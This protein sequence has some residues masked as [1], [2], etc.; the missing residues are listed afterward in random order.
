MPARSWFSPLRLLQ[1]GSIVA[2]AAIIGLWGAISWSLERERAAVHARNNVEL[3]REYALRV[4]ET[5][6][7]LLAEAERLVGDGDVTTVDQR[8]LHERLT[9]LIGR[10]RFTLGVGLISANGEI[11]AST[12]YPISGRADH[13]TYFQRLRAGL[14]DVFVERVTLEGDQ[15]AVLLARR[16]AGDAF[17]GV[18]VAAVDVDAVTEFFARVAGD[19]QA[20]AA[21]YGNDGSLLLRYPPAP[22]TVVPADAP[23]MQ[24]VAQ[25]RS[26]VIDAPATSDD[27]RRLYA[28]AHLEDLPVLV[29]FGEARAAVFRS[30]LS[31][32]LVIAC[33]VAVAG[34][35][36]FAASTQAVRRVKAEERQRQLAFD[37]HLL[38]DA[39]R[40]AETKGQL[41]REAHHRIKNNL[42]MII[43]MIR[44]KASSS[45][46]TADLQDIENRMLA[47]SHVHDLLYRSADSDS[48]IDLG[49][50]LESICKNPSILP[51]ESGIELTCESDPV[52]IDASQAVPLALIAV[53]VL[54]NSLKHAFKSGAKGHIALKLSRLDDTALISIKDDGVGL[55]SA[56]ERKRTSGLRLVEALTQQLRGTLE[57]LTN[58]GTEFRIV[59]PLADSAPA[60][61]R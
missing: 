45:G 51:P 10:L 24:A 17:N 1:I 12:V 38:A 31:S 14:D 47:L 6:Q 55:P 19:G 58:H 21:L 30:W 41:L 20:S 57:I 27:V 22:A 49:E 54:T 42:T 25:D 11:A 2:P 40:A 29:V 15:E 48:Q 36:A 7:S 35:L 34:L 37:R 5:Q 26:D 56:E 61:E 16:R 59:L 39:E 33:L 53:E 32:F 52:V 8:E 28:F 46:G 44:M 23:L 3:L 4:F 9:P 60:V 50:F 43:S 18:L 13:R